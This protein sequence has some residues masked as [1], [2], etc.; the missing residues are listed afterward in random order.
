MS[1]LLLIITFLTSFNSIEQDK[2]KLRTI[3]IDA[4]HHYMKEQKLQIKIMQIYLFL[5]IATHSIISLFM[6]LLLISWV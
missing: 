6:D 3:V 4:F 5:S 1:F 2:Y